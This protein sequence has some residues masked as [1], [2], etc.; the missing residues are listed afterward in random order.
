MKIW[1]LHCHLSGAPLPLTDAI[2][3]RKGTIDKYMGDAIMAFWNAPLSIENHA[4]R[5]CDTALAMQAQ[6]RTLN[7]DWNRSDILVV[8][9]GDT[10]T[11]TVPMGIRSPFPACRRPFQGSSGCFP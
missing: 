5:A 10:W 6:L 1:D 2:I 7:E 8:R 9:D 4:A 11:A 3:A